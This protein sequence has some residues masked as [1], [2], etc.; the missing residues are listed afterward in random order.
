MLVKHGGPGGDGGFGEIEK[1]WRP[2]EERSRVV[3]VC[4]WT[5]YIQMLPVQLAAFHSFLAHDF[6]Y[7][8]ITNENSSNGTGE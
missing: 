6:V 2:R 7:V 4:A 8:A 5:K 3:I 1:F